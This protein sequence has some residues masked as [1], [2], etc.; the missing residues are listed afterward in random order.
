MNSFRQVILD[1]YK[2]HPHAFNKGCGRETMMFW[3]CSRNPGMLRWATPNGVR[4]EIES[5]EQEGIFIRGRSPLNYT[6]FHLAQPSN[7]LNIN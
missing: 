3:V 4:R 2:N 1:A 6:T 5:L 7:E